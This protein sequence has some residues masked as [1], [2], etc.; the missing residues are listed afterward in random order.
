MPDQQALR[1]RLLHEAAIRHAV[2]RLA[3][4]VAH[5]SGAAP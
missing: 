1:N 4:T 3:D 5:L 2:A